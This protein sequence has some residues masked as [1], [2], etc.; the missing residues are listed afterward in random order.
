M[1]ALQT[2]AKLVAKV[3]G[4]LLMEQQ[5][6]TVVEHVN[7]P[8]RITVVSALPSEGAEF[9]ARKRLGEVIRISVHLMKY[10]RVETS[11]VLEEAA[12]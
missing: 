5:G 8:R 1:A 4:V 6:I 3:D 7:A 9:D 2:Y 11:E 10:H 12:E